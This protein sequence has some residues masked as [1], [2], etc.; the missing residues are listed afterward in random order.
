MP[1]NIE[2]VKKKEFCRLTEKRLKKKYQKQK[3]NIK[4]K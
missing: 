2:L 4:N 1:L 3:K